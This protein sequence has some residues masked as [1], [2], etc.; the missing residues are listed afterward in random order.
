[1]LA[2]ALAR[3]EAAG[4]YHVPMEPAARLRLPFDRLAVAYVALDLLVSFVWGVNGVSDV[5]YAVA[6]EAVPTVLLLLMRRGWHRAA[7]AWTVLWLFWLGSA[8]QVFLG[9][10]L[11]V[12]DVVAMAAVALQAAILASPAVRK[13]TRRPAFTLVG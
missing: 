11:A 6:V 2:A 9:A 1:M 8:L 12:A 5:L 13:R 3:A 10:E 4:A 7:V